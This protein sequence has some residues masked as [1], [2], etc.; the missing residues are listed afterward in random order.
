MTLDAVSFARQELAAINEQ[1]AITTIERDACQA[2][3][4]QLGE[5]VRQLAELMQALVAS[6]MR[7]SLHGMRMVV[8]AIAPNCR[9]ALSRSS[10]RLASFAGTLI[11][12]R[13]P[14]RPRRKRWSALMSGWRFFLNMVRR[15]ALYRVVVEAVRESGLSQNRCRLQPQA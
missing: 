1:L 5:P 3:I 7:R 12:L 9:S 15:S 10:G 13:V 6:T 14:Y 11:P 4:D 8:P 2:Q